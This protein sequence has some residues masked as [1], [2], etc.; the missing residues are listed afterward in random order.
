MVVTVG[1]SSNRSIKVENMSGGIQLLG[2][3]VIT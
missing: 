1:L 2:W 3:F